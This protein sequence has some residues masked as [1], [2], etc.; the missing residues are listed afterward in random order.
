M[1]R[2]SS[3]FSSF[4][5]KKMYCLETF[6][7]SVSFW[8]HIS[9]Q[10]DRYILIRCNSNF[11]V[12]FSTFWVSQDIFTI[13]THPACGRALNCR[14]FVPGF[15]SPT[16]TEASL[17]FSRA[18]QAPVFDWQTRPHKRGIG[19]SRFLASAAVHRYDSHKF[20]HI[21]KYTVSSLKIQATILPEI[22]Q[23]FS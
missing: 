14:V 3:H 6:L 4:L 5:T 20:S 17:V 21:I 10:I 7:I 15:V 9:F 8:S 13:V 1:Q 11:N 22:G 23:K 16:L 18:R 2:H 19:M 12:L